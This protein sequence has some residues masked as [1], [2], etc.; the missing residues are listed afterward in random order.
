MLKTGLFTTVF[1]LAMTDIHAAS[2][3]DFSNLVERVSPAVVSVNVV[4]RLAA[5]YVTMRS[6]TFHTCL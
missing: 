1:T 4:K 2:P 6:S 5:R 3:V